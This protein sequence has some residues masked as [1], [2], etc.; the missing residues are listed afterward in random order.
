MN[1]FKHSLFEKMPV[2][3]ILR[4]LALADILSIIPAYIRAGFTTLEITLNSPNATQTIL[5]LGKKFPELNIGA[6][7]VCDMEDLTNAL[8]A[9]ASFIVMPI[10]DEEVVK[11][12]NERNIPVFPGAF[13]PSEIY[14]AAKAGAT[15]VKVFPATKLGPEYIKDVLAPLSHVKLLPTG[16]VSLANIAEF[17]R[18]GAIG[19]G[20]GSTLFPNELV[21]AKDKE[22]LYEHF[23]KVANQVKNSLN[24]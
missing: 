18:A 24:T 7:T 20:M 11:Y 13:T 6:G 2:V 8:D 12:C 21:S 10:F 22:G 19:V 4:N 14:R 15:A 5:Q 9:G 1:T 17:F 16:G 3:G 23:L